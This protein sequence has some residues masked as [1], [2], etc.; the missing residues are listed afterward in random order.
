MAIR[1][2][3][4][5]LIGGKLLRTLNI[6]CNGTRRKAKRVELAELLR[7]MKIGARV[8]ARTHLGTEDIEHLNFKYYATAIEWCRKNA[9]EIGG[10]V[11][12]LAHHIFKA[13]RYDGIVL[14][15]EAIGHCAIKLYKSEEPAAALLISGTYVPPKKTAKLTPEELGQLSTNIENLSANAPYPHIVVGDFNTT[16]WMQLFNEWCQTK[17]IWYLNDPCVS[18]IDTGSSIDEFLVIPGSYIPP[19]FLQGEGVCGQGGV[20]GVTDQFPAATIPELAISDPFPILRLLPCDIEQQAF[21]NN[22]LDL[23]EMPR[24][25]WEIKNSNLQYSIGENAGVLDLA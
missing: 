25:D 19:T 18:T 15:P 20:G 13:D 14:G 6:N 11:L 2:P 9:Q 22:K 23:A 1:E 3:K 8:V 12:V 7:N 16:S 4:V 5:A 21:T 17:G 10:G 24:E